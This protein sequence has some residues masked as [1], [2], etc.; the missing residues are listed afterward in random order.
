MILAISNE[1]SD[2]MK[3]SGVHRAFTVVELVVVIAIITALAALLLPALAKARFTAKKSVCASQLRQVYMMIAAYTGDYATV[4]PTARTPNQMAFGSGTQT[5][6]F[7]LLTW[8]GYCNNQFVLACPDTNYR[9]GSNQQEP[10]APNF[11]PGYYYYWAV[12]R[13][14]NTFPMRGV[15]PYLY[16][17]SVTNSN[18]KQ[19]GYASSYAY[20]R[21]G[22]QGGYSNTRTMGQLP[23]SFIACGQQWGGQ[24]SGLDA[25]QNYTHNRLGSNVAYFDGAVNWLDLTK[26]RDLQGL[27]T[28]PA[29]SPINAGCP[30]GYLP[31]AYAD[32]YPYEFPAQ[33]FWEAADGNF[34]K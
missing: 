6:G 2:T 34:G 13:Q 33:A 17:Q 15:Q 7:G 27:K 3:N 30:P 9:P 5:L 20:R 22:T 26:P 1:A 32:D 12:F 29:N 21:C 16:G 19:Y 10:A 25:Y 28:V 14:P 11:G 23:V 4:P 24:A 18:N 31:F 8:N